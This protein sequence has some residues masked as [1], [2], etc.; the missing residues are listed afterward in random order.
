MKRYRI[1]TFIFDVPVVAII[2]YYLIYR[3]SKTNVTL[4]GFLI[5]LI[6]IGIIPLFAWTYLIKHPGD[7][8]GERKMSFIIDIISYPIGFILLVAM[9][10]SRIFSALALSYLLNAVVLLAINKAG[11]KASGHGAGVA[12]PATALTILFGAVGA[13]SFL[14]LVPVFYSK[15]KLKDHSFQ[16]LLTGSLVS[17]LLTYLSFIVMSAV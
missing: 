1:L 8:K 11:Y 2:S 17:I 12:G 10:E 5:S 3:F 13:I 15:I 16:Q 14:F 9:K 7:Y 4:R 6:F